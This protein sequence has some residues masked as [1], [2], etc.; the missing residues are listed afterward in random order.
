MNEHERYTPVISERKVVGIHNEEED[1]ERAYTVDKILSAF[2]IDAEV[3][4]HR[5]VF[6]DDTLA[7]Y[8]PPVYE[9]MP[10]FIVESDKLSPGVLRTK[11]IMHETAHYVSNKLYPGR[12]LSEA[13]D[14]AIAEQATL[15]VMTGLGFDVQ[16]NC[17]YYLQSS[18][19]TSEIIDQTREEA[20]TIAVI[21]FDITMNGRREPQE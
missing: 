20:D 1:K 14:E 11:T 4:V 21:L 17:H 7:Y 10:H 13:E 19:I 5:T 16:E 15:F 12:D 6:T 3:S 2:L 8:V 18:G 9:G